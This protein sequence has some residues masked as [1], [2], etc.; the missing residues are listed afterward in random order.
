MLSLTRCP[1]SLLDLPMRFTNDCR[2][3]QTDLVRVDPVDIVT[4]GLAYTKRTFR[5]SSNKGARGLTR[6]PIRDYSQDRGGAT[7]SKVAARPMG[8]WDP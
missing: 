3:G 7:R 6:H 1:F 2:I 5:Y 4:K 8:C